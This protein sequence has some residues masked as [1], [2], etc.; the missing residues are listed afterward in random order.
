MVGNTEIEGY[1]LFICDTDKMPETIRIS[2]TAMTAI[3]N[4]WAPAATSTGHPVTGSQST[5]PGELTTSAPSAGSS[6]ATAGTIAGAVAGSVG[7]YRSDVPDR[8][9]DHPPYQTDPLGLGGL[10]ILVI[11]A[12]LVRDIIKRKGR[13]KM[14]EGVDRSRHKAR[15]AGP[16][17]EV[18]PVA[19]PTEPVELP[20]S[21]SALGELSGIPLSPRSTVQ[22]LSP[23]TI[24]QDDHLLR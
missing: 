17:R 1:S 18:R 21:P 12:M 11:G 5:R 15:D 24:D 10:V 14:R 13:S 16:P 2:T 6:P 7:V 3:T 19:L 20:D 22:P 8:P 4:G 23:M 9:V